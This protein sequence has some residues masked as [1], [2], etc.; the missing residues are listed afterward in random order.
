MFY[1]SRRLS[2][3]PVL[4]IILQKL[5]RGYF[6]NFRPRYF[7]ETRSGLT[8]LFDQRNIVD[9]NLLVYG[10]WE[11]DQIATLRDLIRLQREKAA[12]K[13]LFLDVGAHGGLYAMMVADSP[14]FDRIIAFE[15]EP[16]NYAQLRA[17]LF[18]NKLTR[19]IETREFAVSD[20]CGTVSFYAHALG[21]RGASRID[22]Q[23]QEADFEPAVVVQTKTLD[24]CIEACD[25]QI[26]LKIDVEGHERAVLRGMSRLLRENDCI[27]QVE[28]L[29]VDAL[30]EA[31]A[32]LK[33]EN[34]RLVQRVAN[35]YFF[36]VNT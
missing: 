33:A 26:A 28:A 25:W 35:D 19:R 32:I 29:D 2:S 15:P 21:N 24:S 3:I 1:F 6:N 14:G 5:L 11:K 13:T 9:R 27:L 8:L 36:T 17:N 23:G 22:P 10:E 18:M 20:Q 30:E 31:T 7:V 16:Q 12:K 4:G 34:Y